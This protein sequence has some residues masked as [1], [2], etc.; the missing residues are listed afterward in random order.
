MIPHPMYDNFGK[1]IAKNTARK[2]LQLPTDKKI[3]LFFGF[4]RPYK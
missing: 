2:L 1:K 3:L 4:I